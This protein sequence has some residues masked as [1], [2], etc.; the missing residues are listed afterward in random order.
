MRANSSLVRTAKDGSTG[1][2][3]SGA[4]LSPWRRQGGAAWSTSTSTSLRADGTVRTHTVKVFGGRLGGGGEPKEQ[5]DF[6]FPHPRTN[7]GVSIRRLLDGLRAQGVEPHPFG[8]EAD[9]AMVA[10]ILVREGVNVGPLQDRPTSV[11]SQWFGV[12]RAQFPIPMLDDPATAT[13]SAAYGTFFAVL[14]DVADLRAGMFRE[15]VTSDLIWHHI[16]PEEFNGA[17]AAPGRIPMPA[18]IVANLRGDDFG[19]LWRFSL[20]LCAAIVYQVRIFPTVFARGGGEGLNSDPHSD[21]DVVIFDPTVQVLQPDG[22]Y[23][24]ASA[25]DGTTWQDC[26]DGRPPHQNSALIPS[27]WGWDTWYYDPT[28]MVLVP[29]QTSVAYQRYCLNVYNP[30]IASTD[31]PARTDTYEGMVAVRKSLALQAFG[32]GIGDYLAR[33]DS[34][35]RLQGLALADYVP[36]LE[37]GAEMDEQWGQL[38]SLTSLEAPATPHDLNRLLLSAVYRASSREYA[39]FHSMLA[40]GIRAGYPAARIKASEL[41]NWATIPQ[42][43][44]RSAWLGRALT[45]DLDAEEDLLR[46]AVEVRAAGWEWVSGYERAEDLVDVAS[47]CRLDFPAATDLAAH[48]LVNVVGFHWFHYWAR[49]TGATGDWGYQSESEAWDY[50]VE[51]FIAHVVNACAVAGRPVGWGVG[52]GPPLRRMPGPRRRGGPSNGSRRSALEHDRRR[53]DA[54][55]T[56]SF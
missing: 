2:A 31:E 48:P 55:T 13:E 44:G 16:F 19:A 35:L 33:W 43:S 40:R 11:R 49:P 39:R 29:T 5:S 47:S 21:K 52:N 24:S 20:V 4:G 7:Q 27:V 42:S 6:V 15:P 46:Q 45:A 3:G 50:T 26:I 1:L 53:C 10:A 8:A 22:T 36:H 37:L 9:D 41:S 17:R 34:A 28:E 51:P 38:G 30:D 25:P 23:R 14:G 12:D 54:T 18:D 56:A 32:L